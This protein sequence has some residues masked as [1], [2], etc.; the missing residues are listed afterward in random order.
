MK[1]ELIRVASLSLSLSSQSITVLQRTIL[2]Q[3]AE[4]EE[5]GKENGER[6]K[7]ALS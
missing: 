6:G 4:E 3:I 7:S 5:E 2:E 1:K